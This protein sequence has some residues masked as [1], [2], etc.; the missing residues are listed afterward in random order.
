MNAAALQEDPKEIFSTYTKVMNGLL[1]AY[2]SRYPLK[3]LETLTMV[4]LDI[5][6]YITGAMIAGPA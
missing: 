3:P 6:R 1:V 4:P 2:H 5:G